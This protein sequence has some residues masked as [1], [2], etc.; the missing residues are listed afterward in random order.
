MSRKVFFSVFVKSSLKIKNE[1]F[2]FELLTFLF[3]G[4]FEEKWWNELIIN[5]SKP[6]RF[7]FI[8]FSYFRTFSSFLIIKALFDINRALSVFSCVIWAFKIEIF[9]WILISRTKTN[10][11]V[12]IVYVC[13]LCY[14]TMRRF[15]ILRRLFMSIVGW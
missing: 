9:Y 11:F 12:C 3:I 6:A 15:S 1:C 10:R 2:V 14:C 13:F 7:I 5:V 8:V 4:F